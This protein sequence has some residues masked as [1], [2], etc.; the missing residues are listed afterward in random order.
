MTGRPAGH[1]SSRWNT[2]AAVGSSATILL[3]LA[4]LAGRLDAQTARSPG[5]FGTGV[6]AGVAS[7]DFDGTGTAFVVGAV[8]YR[9]F[10]RTLL[11]E[12]AVPVLDYSQD[13]GPAGFG[14]YRRTR[15]LLPEIDAQA[16]ARLGRLRPYV[17]A[18]GGWAIRLNGGEPGGATL[19]AALGARLLVGRA[20]FLRAE[21]RA[22][23]IRPWA[24]STVDFTVGIEWAR[25]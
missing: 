10:G 17:A 2:P 1:L 20:T 7:Y 15:F 4:F 22:R 5:A 25:P 3:G 11:V 23:S 19:H 9:P 16:Q 18:G 14:G 12:L 13:A 21:T 8:L 24:A 6:R